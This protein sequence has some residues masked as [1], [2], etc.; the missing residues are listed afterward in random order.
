[1]HERTRDQHPCEG[2]H[3]PKFRFRALLFLLFLAMCNVFHVAPLLAISPQQDASQRSTATSKTA[4]QP[5]N[6]DSDK[7]SLSD[8]IIQDVLEPLR[9]GV[10]TQN[11]RQMLAVFDKREVSDYGDL[12]QQ[13]HAFFRQYNEVRFRYQLL[14]AAS[15]QDAADGDHATVSAEFDMDAMPY[16]VSSVPSRRSAQMHLSLKREAKGWKVTAFSPA[17]FFNVDYSAK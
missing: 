14:Q 6:A 11:I 17:D 1:M 15:Q 8:Q 10:E 13:L 4:V 3:I 7:L 12:E 16:D 2:M 5:A 9:A